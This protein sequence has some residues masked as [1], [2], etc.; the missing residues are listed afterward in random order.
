V[1]VNTKELRSFLGLAGFYRKFVRHFGLI[2]RP[3]TDLFKENMLFVWTP[4]HQH[5]FEA[6]KH[7]LIS[8]PVLALTDFT[9][10]FCIYIDFCK[11]GIGVVLMQN[12]H[13]LAFLSK[14]LGTKNQ[15]MSTYKKEY[16]AVLAITQ[17]RSYM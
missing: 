1:P 8:V 3:L 5:V 6:L 13:A 10:P 16:V 2:S 7:A 17:W 11:M 12:G 4:E 9:L 14:A 15:G